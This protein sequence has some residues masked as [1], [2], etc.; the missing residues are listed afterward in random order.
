MVAGKGHERTQDYGKKIINFSDQ[1]IIRQ[2]VK[3][4]KFKFK[5]YFYQDFLLKKA[6]RRNDIK[7]VKYNG[8]SIN[9]KTIKKGDLFFC[10]KGKK[11]DGH[12]FAKILN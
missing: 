7:N 3:K 2:I 5:K 4:N 8:I 9:T 1:K 12:N 6:L 11:K 10:M